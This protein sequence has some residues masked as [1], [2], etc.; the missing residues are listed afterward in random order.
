M[1]A[2]RVSLPPAFKPPGYRKDWP[3]EVLTDCRSGIVKSMWPSLLFFSGSGR[4]RFKGAGNGQL[5]DTTTRYLRPG[6][7]WLL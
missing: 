1:L 3:I 4:G 6:L 7:C 2:S 5:G